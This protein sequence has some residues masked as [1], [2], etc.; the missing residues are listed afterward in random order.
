MQEPRRREDGLRRGVEIGCREDPAHI[1]ALDPTPVSAPRAHTLL[2]AQLWSN[3][4][5]R[6]KRWFLTCGRALPDP[7][8][9]DL[10]HFPLSRRPLPARPHALCSTLSR[11][12]RQ[13]TPRRPL[14]QYPFPLHK[15]NR[16]PSRANPLPPI[17]RS[18]PHFPLPLPASRHPS[19]L[20][21]AMNG[22]LPVALGAPPETETMANRAL[23]SVVLSKSCPTPEHFWVPS[24]IVEPQLAFLPHDP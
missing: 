14:H 23:L 9:P 17:R 16:N 8:R 11:L 1:Q 13:A 20:S 21:F 24:G 5:I 7:L 2:R 19:R 15:R 4:G 3:S 6:N 22:D 18:F 10:A 12:L